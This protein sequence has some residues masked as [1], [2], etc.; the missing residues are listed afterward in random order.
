MCGIFI[1]LGSECNKEQVVKE[2]LKID[3]RGPDATVIQYQSSKKTV[4]FVFH[5]L[6]IN[7]LKNID[8]KQRYADVPH[9]LLMFF[10]LFFLL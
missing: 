4:L 6:A 9:I 10:F 8:G 5:R 1:Y 3:Y 2:A 7:G